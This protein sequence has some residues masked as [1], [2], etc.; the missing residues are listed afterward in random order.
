MTLPE[1]RLLETAIL[2]AEE[3][4]FSRT[5]ERLRIDQSTVSKRI[6]EV[7]SLIGFRL[8]ERDHRSV[9]VTDS[10][11]EFI[12]QA[13]LALLHIEKAIQRGRSVKEDAETALHI[14][15]SPCTD[16]FLMSTLLSI[17]LP[18]FPQLRID[19]TEQFSCDLIREVVTGGI[20]LAI[21]TE[22]P[23][24]LLL[25]IIK[26]TESPFYI[27]I[28]ERDELANE[29]SV[30]LESLAGRVWVM[31]ERKVHP[32]IYDSVMRI[33]GDRRV[34]P[35]QLRRVM[36]PEDAYPFIVEDRAVAFLTKSGAL[37]MIRNEVTV[38]PL[39]EIGLM[40]RTYLASR[41]DEKSRA[42][43]ELVRAFMRKISAFSP[44]SLKTNQSLPPR[45][46]EFQWDQTTR[47][48]GR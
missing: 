25:T 43:S 13:R 12:E 2:L 23:N 45:Q 37:R 17:K 40:L 48:S 41:A 8:F 36:V 19:V 26:V 35:S 27:A 7:E 4:H 24:S 30:S 42:V 39:A 9:E 33:S 20:D 29:S 16:P 22:P 34:L 31:F 3:L 32:A 46:F 47:N 1:T 5:A 11:R 28:S 14:G 15:R 44:K 18:L 10:G 21:A 6:D 38:R